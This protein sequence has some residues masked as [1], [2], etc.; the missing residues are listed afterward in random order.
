[1]VHTLRRTRSI[2][3]LALLLAPFALACDDASAATVGEPA[4]GFT[5]TDLQ[6]EE[7]SLADYRG[8]VVVLEWINPHCPFS[9]RHADE[10]TMTG[11]ADEHEV[12]WLAVNS[13]NPEHRDYLEPAEHLAYNGK[14]GIDYPVLY[15]ESGE[16]GRAYD[17]KTTPHMY[18]IGED[19]TLLYDGAIDDDPGGRQAARKRTNYVD[20][21][22]QAHTAGTPVEPATT[23]PYGCS[24]KY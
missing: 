21:G 15:D 1:M 17:A 12:V 13:T 3:V 14:Y 9:E 11:L 18:V 19:G 8:K 22:L 5:L 4:P 16:V 2:L 7:H 20:G 10:K 23:K 24:V 6:G